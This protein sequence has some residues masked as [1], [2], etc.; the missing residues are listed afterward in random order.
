MNLFEQG[1]VKSMDEAVKIPHFNLHDEF[2]IS[3]LKQIREEYNSI[4]HSRISIFAFIVKCFSLAIKEHPKINSNYFP[5]KD[6]YS[7]FINP[8]H[9]ISIAVDSKNGLVAP[10]IKDVQLKSVR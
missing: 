4:S 1:M 9:N 6:N 7:Y 8:S 10:N 5:E 2:N 3:R